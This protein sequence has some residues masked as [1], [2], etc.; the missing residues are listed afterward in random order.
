MLATLR[1]LIISEDTSRMVD[2]LKVGNEIVLTRDFRITRFP[3]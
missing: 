2:L 1:L 3:G